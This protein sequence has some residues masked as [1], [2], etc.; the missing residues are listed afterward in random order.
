MSQLSH[1]KT[2]GDWWGGGGKGFQSWNLKL[3]RGQYTS[4]GALVGWSESFGNPLPPLQLYDIRIESNNFSDFPKPTVPTFTPA[5][6]SDGTAVWRWESWQGLNFFLQPS[7]SN[8]S[9]NYFF[10]FHVYAWE[11]QRNAYQERPSESVCRSPRNLN[12][13]SFWLPSMTTASVAMQS[14]YKHFCLWMWCGQTHCIRIS[15]RGHGKRTDAVLLLYN[16]PVFLCCQGEYVVNTTAWDVLHQFLQMLSGALSS[17]LGP[18]GVTTN[19]P[20]SITLFS[21][22]QTVSGNMTTDSLL[23][24]FIFHGLRKGT[25]DT[26]L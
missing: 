11:R 9:H 17:G 6:H 3:S 5:S 20:Q 13:Y 23:R 7:F 24:I 4:T 12:D 2:R 26:E 8:S 16:L 22:L 1:M 25:K 15:F 10:A 14:S 18:L 21:T 19:L